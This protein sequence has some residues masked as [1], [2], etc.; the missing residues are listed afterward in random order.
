MTYTEISALCEQLT[1]NDKLR[2][3]Q[4]LIVQ[5]MREDEI[6]NPKIRIQTQTE[7]RGIWKDPSNSEDITEYVM[8]RLLKLKPSKRGSLINSIVAM[9]Q[10]QGG[11]S[12]HD[13]ERIVS[14]LEKLKYINIDINNKITYR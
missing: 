5:V 11:I 2:L 3:V 9:F 8:K 6:Q 4:L 1:R 7:L 14:E 10:F 13:V 12:E